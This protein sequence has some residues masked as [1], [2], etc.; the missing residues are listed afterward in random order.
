[1]T[2][3]KLIDYVMARIDDLVSITV[4]GDEGAE[5]ETYPYCVVKFP[6]S[7]NEKRKRTDWIVE[8]DF[9]NNSNAKSAIITAADAL[10]AGFDYYWQSE[11]EGFYTSHIIFYGGIL[12]GK[13][14]LTRIQQRYLL[15]VY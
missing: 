1:M 15:K 2:F 14:N 9:W 5:P 13:E 10:K 11:T 12:T 6:S 7:D 4:C 3:D 8:I